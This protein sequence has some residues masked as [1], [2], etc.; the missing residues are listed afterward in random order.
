MWK[1]SAM[2]LVVFGGLLPA[3]SAFGDCRYETVLSS[4][5]E[6]PDIKESNII[7]RDGNQ[8]SLKA[9][10]SYSLFYA[11]REKSVVRQLNQDGKG[12]TQSINFDRVQNQHANFS[13]DSVAAVKRL[14][15]NYIASRQPWACKK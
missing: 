4:C 14:A 1:T 8:S 7:N 13:G 3:A 15:E 10:E 12:E 9:N 2:C 11:Y 5:Y 6:F